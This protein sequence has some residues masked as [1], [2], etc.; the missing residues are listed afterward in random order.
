MV[1]IYSYRFQRPPQ[2]CSLKQDFQSQGGR[3][4]SGRMGKS[5]T[6]FLS[7][8]KILDNQEGESLGDRPPEVYVVSLAFDMPDCRIEK[9]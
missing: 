8:A 3:V 7:Q 2:V 1:D 9:F 6:A 5:W 4:S